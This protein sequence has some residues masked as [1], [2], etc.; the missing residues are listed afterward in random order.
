MHGTEFYVVIT[1]TG[2][3]IQLVS[4]HCDHDEFGQDHRSTTPD[5]VVTIDSHGNVQGPTAAGQP[6]VN[7]ADLGAPVTSLTL[8]TR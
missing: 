6:I 8:A 2:L 5:T 4:G 1:P 3:Q 7:F